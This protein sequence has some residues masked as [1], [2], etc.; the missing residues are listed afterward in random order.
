MNKEFPEDISGVWPVMLTAFHDSGEIDWHGVDA[1][2]DWYIEAG[3]AGLFSVCLSS[4]MYQ[5][6]PEE[7]VRLAAHVV[8]RAADRVPVVAAGAFGESLAQQAERVK[9][10]ADTGVVAVVLTVNQLASEAEPDAVWQRNA[11]AMLDACGG[12]PLGL[13][14][15]PQPYHRKLSPALLGWTAQTGGFRFLKD[16]CCRR[17]LIEA[18][19][20]AV[21]GTS[22]HWFNANC[23]TLLYSLRLGG[24][25]YSGIAANYYPELFV[26]LCATFATEPDAA[27]GL[28]RFLTLADMTVRHYPASAK[29]YVAGLGLPV[30][31]TCRT[32]VSVPGDNED[33][34]LA[35]AAL[36][37]VVSRI[38]AGQGA[39]EN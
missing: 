37:E 14:E 39:F 12:I 9:Q 23:P 26:R 4:E 28:Q 13:Y 6:S 7:R 30:G 8:A 1:L 17:D 10:L 21:R 18:K 11:A 31:P 2:V 3:V 5:L 33:E 34:A 32:P 36:T 27:V 24:H 35:F 38:K 22:L 20:E 16:T 19:L 25:G 15:C 29:R